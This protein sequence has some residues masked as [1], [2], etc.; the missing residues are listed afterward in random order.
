MEHF[1]GV[2]M[3]FTGFLILWFI[4]EPFDNLGIQNFKTFAKEFWIRV[5]VYSGLLKILD[6]KFWALADLGV[7]GIEASVNKGLCRLGILQINGF[8]ILGHLWT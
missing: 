4:M 2:A 3:R 1:F 8:E 7:C 6:L 5:S